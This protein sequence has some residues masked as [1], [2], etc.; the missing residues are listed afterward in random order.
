MAWPLLSGSLG[1]A[2]LRPELVAGLSSTW[3]GFPVKGMVYLCAVGAAA[4]CAARLTLAALPAA[5]APLARAVVGVA[6]LAYLLGSY[7]VIRSGSG[8]LLP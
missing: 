6:V 1:E 7:A 2:D 5:R 4:F 8:S 3:H